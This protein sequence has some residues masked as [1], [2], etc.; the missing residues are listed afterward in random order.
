M[1][2]QS[3]EYKRSALTYS[4]ISLQWL[5]DINMLNTWAFS[6]I[7]LRFFFSSTSLSRSSTLFTVVSVPFMEFTIIM[8]LRKCGRLMQQQNM[9]CSWVISSNYS[10]YT[11]YYVH[12]QYLKGWNA[13]V[14]NSIFKSATKWMQSSFLFD[15]N[16]A[17]AMSLHSSS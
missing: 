6:I 8:D 7:L 1:C 16:T 13:F 9:K 14:F 15:S 4:L 5:S 10:T 17:H 12:P 11:S 3:N 2:I